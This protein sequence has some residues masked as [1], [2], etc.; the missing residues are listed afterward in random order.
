MN[1]VGEIL[2]IE[3]IYTVWMRYELCAGD[4]L[5]GVD[6]KCVEEI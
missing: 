1:C 4:T 6:M 3:E 5:Y 2:Y